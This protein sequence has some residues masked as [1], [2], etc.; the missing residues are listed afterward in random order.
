MRGYSDV[1]AIAIGFALTVC[2]ASAF[3][4]RGFGQTVEDVLGGRPGGAVVMRVSDG[5]VLA[6]ANSEV[7]CA[8]LHKPGSIFKLVSAFAALSEQCVGEDEVFQCGGRRSV[9]GQ[10]LNCTVPNGHGSLRI[11]TA[12][13]QSCNLTF[14]ELGLRLGADRLL[15]YAGLLG[16]DRACPGY[17]GKQSVGTLPRRPVHPAGVARLAVGQ[18]DGLRITL[19]AAAEM[20]RRIVT[21]DVGPGGVEPARVRSALAA[22][23]AGMREAVTAGTCRSAALS[24]VQVA[25]KTGSTEARDDPTS[26]SAWFVGFAPYDKPEIVV[27]VFTRRGHGFDAAA[28]IARRIFSAYFAP[29]ESR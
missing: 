14:H 22:V 26:R 7:S 2:G 12:L 16:L 18:A 21:A 9:S 23:R 20:V 4:P 29:G 25:G 3:P 19:L 28:P 1:L 17:E 11:R 13:A 6:L 15:R 8:Q 27:V 24:S 10:S 5:K